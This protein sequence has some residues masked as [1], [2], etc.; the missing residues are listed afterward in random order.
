LVTL[1][2]VSCFDSLPAMI[3]GTGA[4][5]EIAKE[6]VQDSVSEGGFLLNGL[7]AALGAGL[8]FGLLAAAFANF[9]SPN[10]SCCSLPARSNESLSASCGKKTLDDNVR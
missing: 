8:S 6:A 7:F 4:T 5:E 2:F 9:D 1:I 3:I 10:E